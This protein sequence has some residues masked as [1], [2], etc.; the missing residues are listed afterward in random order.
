MLAA[1]RVSRSRESILEPEVE[2]QGWLA[3]GTKPG[4]GRR[5]GR[6]GENVSTV[7]ADIPT[8]GS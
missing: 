8:P 5:G 6:C 7:E 4:T 3:P 2:R 1:K